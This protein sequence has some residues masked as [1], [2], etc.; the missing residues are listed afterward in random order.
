ME[1]FETATAQRLMILVKELLAESDVHR[2]LTL[3]IDRTI[4]ATGAERGMIILFD[5]AGSILFE[6]ARNLKGEAIDH[7]EFEVSRTIIERARAAGKPLFLRNALEDPA[8]RKSPSTFRLKI[9]SVICLP[10]LHEG[11]IFGV[12]YL[13]NRTVR[14]MFKPEVCEFAQSFAEFIALAAFHA[15]ERKQL[16]NHVQALEKELRGR[17]D[18]SAI[19]GHDPK[20]VEILKRVYRRD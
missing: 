8:L 13:D 14:G 11:K 6:T 15:L 17:Y 12:V 7:P 4:T 16:R 20:M 3:A 2:V 5:A 18:F 1:N 19:V 9:L 10:L